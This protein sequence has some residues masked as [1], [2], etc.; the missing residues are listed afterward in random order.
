MM[1][2]NQESGLMNVSCLKM[3]NFY[4]LPKNVVN[5]HVCKMAFFVVE[6][7]ATTFML[8]VETICIIL[9]SNFTPNLQSLLYM[10]R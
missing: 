8:V 7:Q 5:T 2:L 3:L 6:Q 10:R 9:V 1:K 4:Q